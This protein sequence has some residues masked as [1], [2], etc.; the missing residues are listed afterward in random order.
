[1]AQAAVGR[2]QL[3]TSAIFQ[4]TDTSFRFKQTKNLGRVPKVRTVPVTG[5]FRWSIILIPCFGGDSGE[6]FSLLLLE[7]SNL[8]EIIKALL[9]GG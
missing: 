6:D 9:P 3:N 4:V 2:G 1:V 8:A 7:G 5:V